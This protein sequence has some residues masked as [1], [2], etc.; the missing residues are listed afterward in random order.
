MAEKEIYIVISQTG[1]ILSRILKI[2]TRDEYNHASISPY[3]DLSRMYSFG[4][5]HPYNPFWGGFVVESK[6]FGTF[7]RFHKT[8]A[9]V[10]AIPVE[11]EQY[12]NLCR[13]LELMATNRKKYHYN[14][15]GLCL[16]VF[17]IHRTWKNRFYCSEFVREMLRQQQIEGVEALPS[18]IHPVHF[19]ALPKAKTVYCG[20]LKDYC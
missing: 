16:A 20:Q 15:M 13:K 5:K 17:R 10:L 6:D 2:I 3:G 14:Y 4:R 8:K 1:T 19:L 11:E 18:I 7:K 12:R 9:Q